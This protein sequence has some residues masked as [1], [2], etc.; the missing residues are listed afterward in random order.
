MI[1]IKVKPIHEIVKEPFENWKAIL[2]NHSQKRYQRPPVYRV[3]KEEGPDHG[4]TFYVTVSLA[5]KEVGEGSGLS[6]KEAEQQARG[7]SGRG[8]ERTPGTRTRGT[9]GE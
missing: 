8:G 4:K 3:V 1:R 7:T 5:N 9:V 6:K 2:Q